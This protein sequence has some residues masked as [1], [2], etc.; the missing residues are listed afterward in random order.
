MI[1]KLGE[2]ER[3]TGDLQTELEKLDQQW[4]KRLGDLEQAIPASAS[5]I[6]PQAPTAVANVISLA[7]RIRDLKKGL[8]NPN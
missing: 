5:E 1:E 7:N 6:S 4:S 2:A 3:E 8:G